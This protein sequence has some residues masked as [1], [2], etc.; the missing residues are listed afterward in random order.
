M[1]LIAGILTTLLGLAGTP[2]IVID[3]VAADTLR[4]QLSCAETLEVRVDNAPNYQLLQGKVDRIRLAGRGLCILPYLRVEA[5][6][7]ETDP[8]SIEPSSIES[9][10][11]LLRQP[12]Q[13]AVRV[14]LK[15]E[16][17]NQALRS[18]TIANSFKGIKI[19]MSSSGTGKAEIFDFVNPEIKFLNDNRIQL[20]TKLQPVPAN[21]NVLQSQQKPPLDVVV[22][23]GLKIIDGTRLELIDP[24][25]NLQGA[26]VPRQITHAFAKGI[27]KVVNLN[28]LEDLGII[29]RVLKLEITDGKLQVIGFARMDSIEKLE[30]RK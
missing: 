25:I 13:A 10:K 22:E 24:Q 17:L 11:L 27:N 9:G 3:R 4:N 6:D 8:I 5:V 14:V 18:P 30:S 26:K 2:G 28:Q 23:A 29:A 20:S 15:S 19:D 16:D 7:L 21:P 1:E 12:L